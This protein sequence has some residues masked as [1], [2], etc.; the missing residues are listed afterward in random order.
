MLTDEPDVLI[1]GLA[2]DIVRFDTHTGVFMPLAGVESDSPVM[3]VNDGCADR[4]R[5]YVFG[6]M[7]EGGSEPIGSSHRFMLVGT[8]Q[9]VVLPYIVIVNSIILSPDGTTLY[10]CDTRS[11]RIHAYDYDG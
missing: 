10:W 11:R 4:S 6:T 9:H 2:K 5:N 3:H 8:L 1:L 7:H